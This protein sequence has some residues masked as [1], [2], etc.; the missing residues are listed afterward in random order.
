MVADEATSW[1]AYW[2]KKM[3]IQENDLENV[4]RKMPTICFGV[5]VS[6]RPVSDASLR[7]VTSMFFAIN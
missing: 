5:N 3:K 4:V 7:C 6:N 1:P 2:A